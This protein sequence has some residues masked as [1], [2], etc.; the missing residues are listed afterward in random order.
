MFN[1]IALPILMS[2][3]WML[4]AQ[5][6]TYVTDAT[7]DETVMLENDRM[8]VLFF[9]ATWCG[10]CQYMKPI[11]NSIKD[12]VDVDIYYL[13][14]DNN[15]ADDILQVTSIPTYYFIKNGR[16]L[17]QTTGTLK[18]A[19][20]IQLIQRHDAMTVTGDLLPY[21]GKPSK[22][23]IKEGHSKELSYDSI[24]KVWYDAAQLNATAWNYTSESSHLQDVQ[25]A[26]VMINRSIEL[27]ETVSA[28]E[29]KAFLLLRLNR[30]KEAKLVIDQGLK[31]ARKRN[32][33]TGILEGLLERL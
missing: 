3:G 30:K 17:G 21:R 12:E 24:D 13:D 23:S 1:R 29:T 27:E 5:A 2:M 9:T 33:F 10:P 19:R 11:I 22:F 4:P 8:V 18:R 32:E 31:L 16:K 25:A 28:L 20:L 15:T 6:Q 7:M 26:L 14:T